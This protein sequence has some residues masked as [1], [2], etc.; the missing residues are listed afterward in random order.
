MNR[1]LAMYYTIA[2]FAAQEIGS[3]RDGLDLLDAV[4][5]PPAPGLQP[6]GVAESIFEMLPITA[7]RP[8]TEWLPRA[9]GYLI[10]RSFF[11]LFTYNLWASAGYAELRPTSVPPPSL[12]ITE[13]SGPTT[14]ICTEAG[15]RPWV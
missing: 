5:L 12:G 13:P 1:D 8:E 11:D 14:R 15:R 3:G 4:D 6:A 7:N 9:D 2:Y 10:G